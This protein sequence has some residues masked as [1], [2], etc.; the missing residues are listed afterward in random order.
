[1]ARQFTHVF[2]FMN[3]PRSAFYTWMTGAPR[4]YAFDSTR[5]LAYTQTVP[6]SIR[7]DYIV[8]DKFRLLRAAGIEASDERLVLPWTAT[9]AEA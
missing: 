8:R 1:R 7:A 6:R 9:D 5:W 3:N 2:D 4:R